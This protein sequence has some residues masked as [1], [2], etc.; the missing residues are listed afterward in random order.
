MAFPVFGSDFKLLPWLLGYSSG[1]V[2]HA[3]PHY[4][5][6]TVAALAPLQGSH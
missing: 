3:G 6:D 4:H 1:R 2:G 5:G